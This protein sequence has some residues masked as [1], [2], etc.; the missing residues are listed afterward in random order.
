MSFKYRFILSFVTLEIFFILLIVIFNFNT[1]S[2]STKQLITEKIDSTMSFM[3]SLIVVPLSIYDLGTL[4]NITENVAELKNINSII[5]LDKENRIISSKFRF[6]YQSID[7]I[8]KIKSNQDL[9]LADKVYELRYETFSEEGI[10]IG[11]IYIIFDHSENRVFLNDTKNNN[12]IFIVLEILF[13]TILAFLVGSKLN[14]KLINLSEVAR[15]IGKNKKIKIPYLNLKDEIGILSNSLNQMQIDLEN[16]NKDLKNL[17]KDLTNQKFELIETQKHKDSFFAN[18]SHELKTPLNSINIL[19]SIMMN[20]K[21]ENL[22]AVQIKNLTIINDCGKK[23]VALINDIMDISKIEA[24]E[25]IVSSKPFDFNKSMNKIYEMFLVQIQKKGLE[26]V[27]QKDPSFEFIKNDEKL[28][29]QILINI[30]SNAIKFTQKGKIEFIINNKN[31]FIEFIIKDDGIG[32]PSDKLQYIFERFKQVDG[33]L[34]RKYEGTGLGLSISKELTSMLCGNITVE[35]ELNKGS[36][37]TILIK[38]NIETQNRKAEDRINN[39]KKISPKKAHISIKKDNKSILFMNKDPLYYLD[40]VLKL[41]KKSFIVKQVNS[42]DNLL[43]ELENKKEFYKKIVLDLDFIEQS[44]LNEF[45][46]NNNI[47]ILFATSELD[48]IDENLKNSNTIILDKSQKEKF[49]ESLSL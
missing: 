17:T 35:S 16:R 33:S 42:L 6:K 46:K 24:G 41:K 2:S 31:E 13:S 18:M 48:K 39:Q 28:I 14:N 19:S 44:D 34:N 15:N 9:S 49:V 38:K 22:D 20:N 7:E 23:L 30:L 37:F 36:K 3:K 32:I 10:Y 21:K 26:F 8:L 11:S 27:F 4:D 5:I 12:I 47:D 40:I 29:G 1:I 25:L 43:L 45:L